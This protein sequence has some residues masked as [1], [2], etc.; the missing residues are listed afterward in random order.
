[1]EERPMLTSRALILPLP[2]G[3]DE[4]FYYLAKSSAGQLEIRKFDRATMKIIYTGIIVVPTKSIESAIDQWVNATEFYSTDTL[5]SSASMLYWT[6]AGNVFSLS[7]EQFVRA[8]RRMSFEVLG[9]LSKDAKTKKERHM[10]PLSLPSSKKKKEG[11]QTSPISSPEVATNTND[12]DAILGGDDDLFDPTDLFDNSMKMSSAKILDHL[13]T[14]EFGSDLHKMGPNPMLGAFDGRNN[15]AVSEGD[16]F[17]GHVGG[18][19][20]IVKTSLGHLEV[21]SKSDL[22][23]TRLYTIDASTSTGSNNPSESYVVS[24]CNS[25]DGTCFLAMIH[26][27]REEMTIYEVAL[28]NNGK[29][30]K[31]DTTI[32]SKLFAPTKMPLLSLSYHQEDKQLAFAFIVTTKDDQSYIVVRR[33]DRNTLEISSSTYVVI[34]L[35]KNQPIEAMSLTDGWLSLRRQGSS[36]TCSLYDISK[37]SIA[38]LGIR[39][40]AS[41]L[42]SDTKNNLSAFDEN[43]KRLHHNLSL[44]IKSIAHMIINPAKYR[45]PRKQHG[46]VPDDHLAEKLA[47]DVAG[48]MVYISS[49]ESDTADHRLNLFSIHKVPRILEHLITEPLADTL[50]LLSSTKHIPPLGNM[51]KVA[52]DFNALSRAMR[53]VGLYTKPLDT[54]VSHKLTVEEHLARAEMVGLIMSIIDSQRPSSDNDK[55]KNKT[56]Y[57][58]RDA[59]FI[60]EFANKMN[61]HHKGL[62]SIAD[63]LNVSI[64]N[65]QQLHPSDIDKI[66]RLFEEMKGSFIRELSISGKYRDDL[67][68][69]FK[70]TGAWT[71]FEKVFLAWDKLPAH[72]YLVLSERH[73]VV[74]HLLNKRRKENTITTNYSRQAFVKIPDSV[75]VSSSLLQDHGTTVL[76]TQ[77]DMLANA[78]PLSH[79][80]HNQSDAE[81]RVAIIKLNREI[82]AG[83]HTVKTI[84]E[85]GDY[86]GGQPAQSISRI[87]ERFT[88]TNKF[89]KSAKLILAHSHNM[90]DML[91]KNMKSVKD[92]YVEIRD[93]VRARDFP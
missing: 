86:F 19:V 35:E 3:N 81:S 90:F 72:A 27:A 9:V 17:V 44:F 12:D 73:H 30:V 1:M 31:R 2:H 49:L 55:E 78:M 60:A 84:V 62:S 4:T 65:Q 13:V 74:E 67:V 50:L 89:V 38:Q 41:K 26:P 57:S 85:E 61:H 36:K 15:F 11:T 68:K 71:E 58:I 56:N 53:I 29:I 77:L 47:D 23:K 25:P 91:S 48:A 87:L 5:S 51:I 20:F 37:M 39:R 79:V 28:S 66:S 16:H 82:S 7:D 8:E 93:V 32:S 22:N 42:L 24:S 33:A 92:A 70:N 75:P 45:Q 64:S 43:T 54:Y 14:G 18:S 76:F 34:P 40:K 69:Y 21:Y 83:E 6:K 63:I 59:A 52:D 10:P 80:E 46:D 88:A